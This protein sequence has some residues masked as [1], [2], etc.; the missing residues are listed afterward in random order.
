[1]LYMQRKITI[2]INLLQKY[3]ARGRPYC[4][5]EAIYRRKRI[6]AENLIAKLE[7][8]LRSDKSAFLSKDQSEDEIDTVV[9]A[10]VM[11]YLEDLFKT[12]KEEVKKINENAGIGEYS[13]LLN[14]FLDVLPKILSHIEYSRLIEGD[15]HDSVTGVALNSFV[16]YLIAIE[17]DIS[18]D[19]HFNSSLSNAKS[20]YS[21]G[22]GFGH[23]DALTEEL[24]NI[25]R[26]LILEINE[27]EEEKELSVYDKLNTALTEDEQARERYSFCGSG[28]LSENIKSAILVIQEL[29]SFKAAKAVKEEAILNEANEARARALMAQAQGCRFQPIASASNSARGNT[30][31]EKTERRGWSIF[32]FG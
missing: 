16:D 26:R 22:T 32:R 11:Y 23:N 20:R 21:L 12:E 3:V 7:E 8:L 4:A 30:E 24:S 13:L 19:I 5:D 14:I 2:F 6:Y 1:M 17:F 29:P 31:E 15:L 10:N 27:I 28:R 9:N 18:A 25:S